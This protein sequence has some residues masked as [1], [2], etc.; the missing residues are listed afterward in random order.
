MFEKDAE[1]GGMCQTRVFDGVTCDLGG[2]MIYPATYPTIVELAR[3]FGQTL[4]SDFPDCMVSLETG[5]EVPLVATAGTRAAKARIA[6]LLL[7]SGAL[8]PGLQSI[9]RTL[10]MP[11]ADWLARENLGAI[12]D[13]MGPLFVGAGYGYLEDE[14]PATYLAK[15]F[16]HTVDAP[17][18][19]NL[20]DG[21]QTLWKRV[22]ADLRDV[23]TGCEVQASVRDAS[24]V[25]LTVRR[26]DGEVSTARFDRTRHRALAGL[27]AHLARFLRRG[28]RPLRARAPPPVCE[29]DR[30]RRGRARSAARTLVLPPREHAR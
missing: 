22:A 7:R 17:G 26:S 21:Y 9:G 15:L 16:A 12:W 24:G 20:R 1:V 29:R 25:T 3:E 10:A 23:R 13:W 8:E 28:A 11:I 4:V 30:R 27:G 18:R 19:Y 14:V 5:G 6:Q 2:H